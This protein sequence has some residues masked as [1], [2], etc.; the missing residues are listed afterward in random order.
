M[1]SGGPVSMLYLGT[2][3]VFEPVIRGLYRVLGAGEDRS[4]RDE[5]LA[6]SGLSPV[7]SWWHA[8]SLGEVAAL[9]PVL[10]LAETRA[11]P[12][13]YAVT[14]TSAT[15]R[16]A[17]R[18]RWPQAA[19]A[20]MDLPRTVAAALDA[21]RPRAL[22][23]VETELWPN[24]LQAARSR[25]TRVAV[26]NGRISDRSWARLHWGK[27]VPRAPRMLPSGTWQFSKASV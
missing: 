6:R 15:G 1:K 17:A 25:N 7:D 3:L 10:S 13:R 16:A 19:L 12:G 8:A 26:L 22:V 18:K 21:R 24:L 9:E 20:P 4:L 5:R 11:L 23:L 14:T 27:P 2:T